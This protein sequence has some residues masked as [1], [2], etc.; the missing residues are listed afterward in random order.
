MALELEDQV[1]V[2]HASVDD[3]HELILG[4]KISFYAGDFHIGKIQKVRFVDRIKVGT[5]MVLDWPFTL[6]LRFHSV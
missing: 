4:E 1:P 5:I 2:L 3:C 6:G